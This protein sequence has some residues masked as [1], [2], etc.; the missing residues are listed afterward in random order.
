MG[1]QTLPE[2]SRPLQE[3]ARGLQEPARALMALNTSV[4]NDRQRYT[5]HRS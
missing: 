1:R 2:A 3:G 5:V 4:L